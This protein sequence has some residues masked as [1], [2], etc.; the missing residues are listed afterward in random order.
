MGALESLIKAITVPKEVQESTIPGAF[1]NYNPVKQKSA[2]IELASTSGVIKKSKRRMPEKA[3][4]EYLSL[5][6]WH[7]LLARYS[8]VN[9]LSFRAPMPVGVC[10]LDGD[11]PTVLMEFL[12]GYEIKNM[13]RLKRTT[14]VRIKGQKQPLPL[15]PACALHLGALNR[16]KEEEGLYHSDYDV[17][18]IKFNFIDQVFMGVVDLENARQ[19]MPEPIQ[20]ES[21]TMLEKFKR[22]TSSSAKDLEALSS[23]YH[24]GHEGLVIPEG[25]HQLAR[26]IEEVEKKYGIKLDYINKTINGLKTEYA[27]KPEAK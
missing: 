15:Y 12:Q 13:P 27:T 3:V 19:D 14:P 22:Y 5:E 21:D 20:K 23:W 25:G 4:Y 2:H 1:V 24:E 11:Y 18:H 26:V 16:I 10:Y 6:I 8:A 7:N 17:R 9:N